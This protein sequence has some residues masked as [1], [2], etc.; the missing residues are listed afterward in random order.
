MMGFFMIGL[1]TFSLFFSAL[2]SMSNSTI[3]ALQQVLLQKVND[4]HGDVFLEYLSS[5]N[6]IWSRSLP[7]QYL[8][9]ENEV[10]FC[11]NSTDTWM[12]LL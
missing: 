3:L 7:N 6:K 10:C 9:K 5:M 11:W 4:D 8:I 2:L 12:E 1:L